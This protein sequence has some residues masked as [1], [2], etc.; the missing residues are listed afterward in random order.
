[1]H[2][3]R[4]IPMEVS[5]D[6]GNKDSYLAEVLS[7]KYVPD[8]AMKVINNDEEELY[9]ALNQLTA[10]ERQLIKLFFFED[11]SEREVAPIFGLSQKGIHQRKVKA[12]A[13]LRKMIKK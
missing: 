6:A 11:K 10:D 4:H 8:S 9:D 1:M 2:Y 5:F 7:S 12:L 13:K 3:R